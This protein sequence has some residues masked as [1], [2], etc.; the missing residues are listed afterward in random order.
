MQ[1]L[2]ACLPVQFATAFFTDLL[3]AVDYYKD[4]QPSALDTYD[5]E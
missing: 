1:A 2:R 4:Q 5:P 3:R